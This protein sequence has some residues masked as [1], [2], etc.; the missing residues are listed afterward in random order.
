[1]STIPAVRKPYWAGSEPVMSCRL[2]TKRGSSS[3]PKPEMPS[4][5]RT[6]FIRYC[7]LACSPRTCRSPLAAES[8]AT[9]GARSST[10]LKGASA[11]WGRFWIC[12]ESMTNE[13]APSLGRMSSRAWS[14][15]A[16]TTTVSSRT[17][18]PG[19]AGGV[20]GG[21]ESAAGGVVW[22]ARGAAVR[23]QKMGKRR[24]CK[25]SLS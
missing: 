9:P 20:G 11:P 6:L 12:S 10:W 7:R 14:R 17:V 13:V 23:M 19:A 24:L 18:W 8:S 25:I 22:A 4:G 2:F 1:M 16:E 3:S 5:R 15:E 21:P